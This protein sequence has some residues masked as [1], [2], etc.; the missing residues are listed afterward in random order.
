MEPGESVCAVLLGTA[1]AA[2]KAR[3][4]AES[5][6]KCPY[7]ASFTSAGALV[8][9]VYALPETRRWWLTE[10][11]ESPQVLSLVKVA[12]LFTDRIAASSPWTRGEVRP[13]QQAGPCG[14]DCPSCP[15]YQHRCE[16]C[17]STVHY[18]ASE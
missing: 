9:G 1:P 15:L 11:E 6:R 5:L 18:V 7:V 10:A 14:A 8:I 16:G 12:V 13:G 2:D 3:N 4:L 17:P